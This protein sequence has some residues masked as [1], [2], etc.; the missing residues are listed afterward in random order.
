VALAEAAILFEER[1]SNHDRYGVS[2]SFVA[3]PPFNLLLLVNIEEIGTN[4]TCLKNQ[5]RGSLII[6][7]PEKILPGRRIRIPVSH[8][9][10]FSTILDYLDVPDE[11]DTSDGRS[12]R[13][14]IERT[15]VG[16]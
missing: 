7:F 12:L 10:V 5:Q 6:S 14:F 2:E 11:H 9:D 16:Q 8:I 15:I 4:L 3:S 1:Q 13:R